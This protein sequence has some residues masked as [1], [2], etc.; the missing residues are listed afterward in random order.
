[1][2]FVSKIGVAIAHQ[3]INLT[4][5]LIVS[6]AGRFCSLGAKGLLPTFVLTSK[7]SVAEQMTLVFKVIMFKETPEE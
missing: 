7:M 6:A 2:D 5:L 1:M 3:T 4:T